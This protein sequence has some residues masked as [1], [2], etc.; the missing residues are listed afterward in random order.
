LETK[1]PVG[2]CNLYKAAAGKGM[3]YQQAKAVSLI[4]ASLGLSR[5][6]DTKRTQEKEETTQPATGDA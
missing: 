6:T 3:Y 4:T 2:A 1:G 5:K